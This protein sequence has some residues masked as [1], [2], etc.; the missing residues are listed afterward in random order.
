MNYKLQHYEGAV[1]QIPKTILILLLVF[2]SS[3][4]KQEVFESDYLA[5]KKSAARYITFNEFKNVPLA[6]K[7][8]EKI[9]S[10]IKIAKTSRLVYLSQFN[11]SI[12]TDKILLIEKGENR[13]F[14]MP[15]YRDGVEIEVKTENLILSLKSTGEFE[16]YIAKYTLTDDEKEKILNKEYVDLDQKIEI[17]PLDAVKKN[18]PCDTVINHCTIFRDENGVIVGFVV[19]YENPCPPGSD[20]GSGSGGDGS[21]GDGSSGDGS[22]GDGSGGDGSG[23]SGYGGSGYGDNGSSGG[24]YSGTGG[25]GGG[26]ETDNT[27]T[28]WQTNP[29]NVDTNLVL[30]TNDLLT[31]PVMDDKKHIK[32]LN[33]LTLNNNDGTPTVI[34]QYID[35]F[36][37]KLSTLYTEDGAHFIKN[38]NS[39]NVRPADFKGADRVSYIP[40][41]LLPNTKVVLH[42]HEITAH[43]THIS[44][45]TGLPQVYNAYPA[46]IFS[47]GDIDKTGEQ[48]EESGN[49]VDF[50]SILVTEAGVFALRVDNGTNLADT[51]QTLGNDADEKKSFDANFIQNVIKA[52]DGQ[53]NSVYVEN[54]VT[55]LNTQLVNGHHIGLILFQAVFDAQ[56][57]I[58]NWI[59]K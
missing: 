18:E 43:I 36:K 6:V 34:K 37:A 44:A 25:G 22:G 41:H 42:M 7:Q 28:P 54:F 11:F 20:G 10:K 31:Y 9:E 17:I 58:T 39:F 15:I 38:G 14:T 56:G 5:N 26:G 8:F 53:G 57:N 16:A 30:D 51:S 49:D 3:C 45:T 33:K 59:K 32:T 48:F 40:D 50:T 4:V 12:D 55:F 13:S 29:N 24:T 21:G 1:K 19:T 35:D 52:S 2:L 46:P 23:G 27:G 47:S